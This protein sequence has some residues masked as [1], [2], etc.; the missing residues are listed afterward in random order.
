MF[1]ISSSP[2]RAGV[3]IALVVAVS[4]CFGAAA[5]LSGSGDS[6]RG[7]TFEVALHDT[8]KGT[9]DNCTKCHYAWAERFDYYRGWDRYGYVFTDRTVVGFYDPWNRPGLT[10]EFDRYYFTDWWNTGGENPWPDDIAERAFEYSVLSRPGELPAIPRTPGD[11][12]GAVIVVAKS[13][14][15]TDSIAKA[16]KRA[17]PGTTVFIRPGEYNETIVLKDGVS[18]V[19][20]KAETTIINPLNRGHAVIAANHSLIA[21]FT[22][23][24]TG[25][26]YSTRAFNCAVYVANCDSTCVIAGNIFRENGLFGVWIDG[27][28][29]SKA[30]EALEERVGGRT[31]EITDLPFESWPNP[32]VCGNT[33]YR[34]GQRGVFCVHSRG[35]IFNN[36]FTG[37]VKAV[38]LEQHARP[39]F[40]HNVCFFNNVPMAVNRS[41]PLVAS[42]IFLMNQWGQRML[43][44]ANP[45]VWSNVTFNSPF[46]RDFDEHGRPIPYTTHPGTGE[47]EINPEFVMPY[48]GKFT[49]RLSSPL[50]KETFGFDAVGIMRDKGLPQPA[51]VQ[52]KDSYGREVLSMTNE[53]MSLINKVDS[54]N[55]KI[56]TLE[57]AYTV[58]YS[59]YVDPAADKNGDPVRYAFSEP[60]NPFVT[61]THKVDSFRK[62]GKSWVKRYN[63]I[64]AAA[65]ETTTS[66]GTLRYDGTSFRL[67]NA[68][69]A[70]RTFSAPD[71][72]FIGER[73]FRAEPG[74][75]YRD[76]DQYVM[77]ACGPTGT[78]YQGYLRI[79]GGSIAGER[80]V[81]DGHS[82]VKV[83]YPH[84]GK[85]QYF[86]FF[87]DPNIG[88]RPRKIVQYYYEVPYRVMDGY[89]YR[90][91]GGVNVPVRVDVTDYVVVPGRFQGRKIAEW[92]MT[93]DEGSLKVNN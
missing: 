49:F 90:A 88:W 71:P 25:I 80:V 13:G 10:N 55:E 34:I 17:K 76:Y 2:L 72:Q 42:N 23:T 9:P 4:D 69:N 12:N 78:F 11:V 93:V 31:I 64:R 63:E 51:D 73:P 38:G 26:D 32:I 75:F 56:R 1:S 66:S 33:F 79:I 40:H 54:E 45:V 22:F 81:I 19:G 3:A 24:G 6:G 8:P 14:G 92:H 70:G 16:V 37:N 44:G 43:R 47:R 39:F 52:C 29:D 27:S 28:I 87:I 65:G 46:F 85:D 89:V 82:C 15:D 60:G 57:A 59:S 18:L 36:V 20:E 67:E 77:G 62:D 7:D 50:G 5:R 35:E 74:G 68:T 61:V 21:G 41:Q 30:Y 53:I 86:E 48:A 84:I 58:S 83:R 91:I